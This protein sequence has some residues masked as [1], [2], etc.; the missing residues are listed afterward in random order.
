M[1]CC[2]QTQDG[3]FACPER[4]TSA[5]DL[6][7]GMSDRIE[8]ADAHR[9]PSHAANDPGYR[10]RRPMFF[11]PSQVILS[12]GSVADSPQRELVDAICALYPHA[13]VSEHLDLPHNRIDL[14]VRDPMT[15]HYRGKETLV[16]GEH[17]SAVRVSQE[18]GNMCPNYWHFSPYG[19]CPYDCNYCYL[20]ATPGVR[21]SPS[22]KIFLNLGEILKDIDRIASRI[23]EPMAFYL[24]KL[25][26]GL[27]LD[28]LTG[29]SRTLVPFFAKHAYARLTLLTK[30]IDVENL[31]DLDHRGHTVLSWS[32]NPTEVCAEF[33]ANT[34]PLSA[35]IK[36]MQ[37][38]SEAGYPVRAV[39][40]PIIPVPGWREI[41]TRF[42]RELLAQMQL[43]RI[44]L[45]G[46]CSY[47]GALSFTESKLGKDNTV[48][49]FLRKAEHRCP[50]GRN[51]YEPGQRIEIYC[52]L[53]TTIR[54]LQ[55]ELPI[56]LCLEEPAV[57]EELGL[58]ASAGRCNCVL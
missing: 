41:Y 36:A 57:F 17:R 3:P 29:Y 51:R 58:T 53:T 43:S 37:Q 25:Q 42:L 35:R 26:D 31:L 11:N 44:T 55:N 49:L 56:G 27:A 2:G 10:P 52:H 12:K 13:K 19:F 30:A 47:D 54:R 14:G 39:I 8:W 24:G 48:S 50:D 32:L 33:E 21:F 20:A 9:R 46:I 4:E 1:G 5:V 45:G 16:L 18:R 40:M 38:C 6:L 15:L 7:P 28:P 22:V 23:G 34:P